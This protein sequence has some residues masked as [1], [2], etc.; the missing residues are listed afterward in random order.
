MVTRHCAC[1]CNLTYQKV[2]FFFPIENVKQSEGEYAF[3]HIA[4]LKCPNSFSEEPLLKVDRSFRLPSYS[5][6]DLS[7]L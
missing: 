5:D 7:L 1:M 6:T 3:P 2:Q 4:L